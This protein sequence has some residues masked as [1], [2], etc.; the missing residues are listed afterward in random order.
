MKT[1]RVQQ[2]ICDFIIEQVTWWRDSNDI[3]SPTHLSD[4]ESR[5][6]DL[7]ED[8]GWL[9]SAQ[10]YNMNTWLTKLLA[11]IRY[12]TD[13]IWKDIPGFEGKYQ[14]SNLGRIR[15]LGYTKIGARNRLCHKGFT[16][17][18]TKKTN[19]GYL[20]VSLYKDDAHFTK[21]VHRLVA[22]TFLPNPNNLPSINHKNEIKTDNRL[23]NLEWCDASYNAKYGTVIERVIKTRNE[24]GC[25]CAEKPVEQR[26]LKGN[27]IATYKSINEAERNTDISH[28]SI[29]KV[30][31]NI[32]KQAGGYKWNYKL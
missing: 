30:C 19:C 9:T 6:D 28:G 22:Q 29:V 21:S 10:A 8:E 3:D 16:I 32:F 1:N 13:E 25:R 18:K 27:L 7:V 5:L 23:D 31:Q 12:I 15:N 26:D 17:L 2:H 14:A 20:Q 11:E 24:S 4:L